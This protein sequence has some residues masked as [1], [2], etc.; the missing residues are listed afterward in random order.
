M[1][2]CG[3]ALEPG[4]YA[5]LLGD[6]VAQAV[7]TDPPYNVKIAGNVG[8]LGTVQHNEFLMGSGEMTVEE[9]TKFLKTAFRLLAKHSVD[10]SIHF[11]FM[12]FRH[13]QEILSAGRAAYTELKNL[14]IWVK[15]NGGM[16]TFY[17]S[18]HELVFAFKSGTAPHINNFELGQHGRYR[19]NVW[20]YRGVN[21]FGADRMGQLSLHPTTKP[22]A[23]LADA[24]KD[25]TARNG[26]V[27]DVFG[28]SGSTL[29][30]AHKT[31]RRARIAELDPVYVDRIVRRWQAYA[32]DDAILKATGETFD[33]VVSRRQAE[34]DSVGGSEVVP[35]RKRAR[36]TRIKQARVRGA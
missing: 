23:M 17:R 22:V 19:T 16:G 35:K 12:D 20:E 11:I 14:V 36:S 13:L 30:A 34:S 32:N 8:G 15:D 24:I 3:N 31:G 28:G 25:V 27:L 29:I 4:T 7:V 9:F 33:Q 1:L 18:R 10:G 6:D 26:I 21:S 2:V 5:A